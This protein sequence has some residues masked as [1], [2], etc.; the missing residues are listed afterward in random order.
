MK[1]VLILLFIF[2]L[3]ACFNY[4]ELNEIAIITG[5]A[6]DKKNNDY[7]IT[8]LIS[9]AKKSDASAKEGNSQIT[10]IEG[11]GKTISEAF[12]E[13]QLKLPRILYLKHIG[14]M[15]ISDTLAKEGV[16]D[17]LDYLIRSPSSPNRFN[18]IIAKD[19]YASDILKI[20]SPLESFPSQNISLMLKN[21]AINEG[22]TLEVS[23]V[24]FIKKYLDEG[25]DQ[26]L[27]TIEIVGN[28]KKGKSEDNIKT[29]DP[30]TY[31]KLGNTAI[32]N[33][34]KLVG[35]ASERQSVGINII[36]N[37][38]KHMMPYIKCDEISGYIVANIDY[39][40]T[41]KQIDE[42]YNVNID[43]E[44]NGYISEASCD[45]DLTNSDNI[46]IIEKKFKNDIKK[47]L[48]ETINLSKEYN[49][50]IFGFGNIYYK[51]YPDKWNSIKNTWNTM[52]YSKLNPKIKI[53]VNLK[54]KGSANKTLKEM[55]N[56]E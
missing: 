28:I 35:Y 9:N 7:L 4:T 56:N 17:I 6:V 8:A 47:I 3:T 1:K 40:K 18:I 29:S 22:S 27:P 36:N 16:G 19:T 48:I 44:M 10:T 43:V 23:Y 54:T 30:S 15:V 53:D 50:D 41:S 51:K 46:D 33:N 13:I 20:I 5:I 31:V 2:L 39:L 21:T 52:Y 38:I 25:I 12:Q 34:G 42:K 37:N 55:H 14:V 26:I 45:I 11:S 49:T 32:L 24:D